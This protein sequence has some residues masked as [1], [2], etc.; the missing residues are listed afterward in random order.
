M[1]VSAEGR[2]PSLDRRSE[3]DC[4]DPEGQHPI[5][6]GVTALAPIREVPLLSS[7]SS[8]LLILGEFFPWTDGPGGGR[9]AKEG[10]VT[11]RQSQIK[12][13]FEIQLELP[14]LAL[15]VHNK[16]PSFGYS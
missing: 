10:I 1:G 7:L 14:L 4:W 6:R 5:G 3:A 11:H 13:L 9:M 2:A 12:R 15:S 16:H 8:F